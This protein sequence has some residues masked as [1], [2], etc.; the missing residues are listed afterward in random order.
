MSN[1]QG[2]PVVSRKPRA[3]GGKKV[4]QSFQKRLAYQTLINET[5]AKLKIEETPVEN[6]VESDSG[7]LSV[8]ASTLSTTLINIVARSAD[9]LK[10]FLFQNRKK[11]FEN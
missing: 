9:G 3:R 1:P 7:S 2:I 5:F 10:T 4:R 6:K 11:A 8:Q